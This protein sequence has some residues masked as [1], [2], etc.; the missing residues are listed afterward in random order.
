MNERHKRF[1]IELDWFESQKD[2]ENVRVLKSRA[3]NV[4][5]E[6]SKLKINFEGVVTFC[7][8]Q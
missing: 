4:D 7:I 3:Q 8:N 2:G 1:L 5:T 6:K